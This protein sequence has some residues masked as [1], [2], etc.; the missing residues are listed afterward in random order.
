MLP[1]L[2]IHFLFKIKHGHSLLPGTFKYFWLAYIYFKSLKIQNIT[3]KS[4]VSSC[5]LCVMLDK[6]RALHM[7]NC[8]LPKHY[9][10]GPQKV[11]DAFF[12]NDFKVTE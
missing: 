9:L 3:N 2:I 5:C 7:K 10:P 6:P 1:V 11:S 4:S 8:A 12:T